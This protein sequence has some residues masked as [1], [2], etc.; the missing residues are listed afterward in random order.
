M[1]FP[2]GE[3]GQNYD[4]KVFNYTQGQQLLQ[5]GVYTLDNSKAKIY[6][7]RVRAKFTPRTPMETFQYFKVIVLH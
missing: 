1:L 7:M 5:I 4:E 2:G 3:Y 6:E